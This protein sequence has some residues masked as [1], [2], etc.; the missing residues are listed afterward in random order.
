MYTSALLGFR[1]V[2]IAFWMVALAILSFSSLIQAGQQWMKECLV[3]DVS[4]LHCLFV[5]TYH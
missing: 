5:A 2:V 1:F 4:H 3:L